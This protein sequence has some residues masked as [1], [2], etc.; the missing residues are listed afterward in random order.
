MR[1]EIGRAWVGCAV[2]VGR[3]LGDA[4]AAARLA[5]GLGVSAVGDEAIDGLGGGLA[6]GAPIETHAA[7][8]RLS[9]PAMAKLVERTAAHP[10][11]DAPQWLPRV[12]AKPTCSRKCQR[13]ARE[14]RRIGVCGRKGAV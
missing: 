5:L 12:A 13:H 1:P 7:T 9:A 8:D 6:D 3:G 10:S 4:V 2:G 11:L 14:N